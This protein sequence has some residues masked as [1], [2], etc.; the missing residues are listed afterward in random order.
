MFIYFPSGEINLISFK[1]CAMLSSV[2]T[3]LI[4]L[5]LIFDSGQHSWLLLLLSH[6]HISL[7]L[8]SHFPPSHFFPAPLPF[9]LLLKFA[10]IIVTSGPLHVLSSL[11]SEFF[12]FTFLVLYSNVKVLEMFPD[13][14]K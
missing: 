14:S 1:I 3:F 10:N 5:Q 6:M 11:L 4:I 8:I 7:Y 2:M 9:L 13:Y 12:S